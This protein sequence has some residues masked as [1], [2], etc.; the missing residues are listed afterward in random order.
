[1][2][3]TVQTS[4]VALNQPSFV[5]LFAGSGGWTLGLEMAGM[6]HLASLDNDPVACA[7]AAHNVSGPVF[8]AS[9]TEPPAEMLALTPDIVVGSP[10]CQGFSNQGKKMADDPR[11]SL[12][13]SFLDMIDHYRPKA[14]VFENVPGFAR[15][16]KGR[17]LHDVLDRLT[18]SEYAIEYSILNAADYGV[19]QNRRRFFLTG[20]RLSTSPPMPSPTHGEIQNLLAQELM[21]PVSI[22]DAIGDLPDV[23]PG[24]RVGNFPYTHKSFSDFQ[25]WVREGAV[26][27]RQHTTQ[28]HSERVLEKIRKVGHGQNMGVFL[29]DYEENTTDYMGGY[30]RAQPD[31]PSYTAYWTRGMTSIHPFQDRFL[32]PRE[33]A[34]IQSFPDSFEFV[35]KSIENYRL[36]C[37]A[38]PPL[39]SKSWGVALK[40]HLVDAGELEMTG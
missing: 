17:Y 29:D 8:C 28:N 7:T 18:G 3:R 4:E 1:M 21:R 30:R 15:L 5:D 34:R 16:Y 2:L 33:C 35:G 37:N 38:V 10:P 13:W 24:E 12:V 14:W 23:G 9:I 25:K 22:W 26:E 20:T 32:S 6:R 27:V 31:A 19:P 40:Q 39:L 36:I 11:N